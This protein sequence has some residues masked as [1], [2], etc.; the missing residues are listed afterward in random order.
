MEVTRKA[1]QGKARQGKSIK[2]IRM[3]FRNFSFAFNILF[4]IGAHQLC[5][6]HKYT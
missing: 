3:A 1:R 2:H 5:E 6:A 4:E